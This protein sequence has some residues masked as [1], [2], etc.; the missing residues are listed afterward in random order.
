MTA[1]ERCVERPQAGRGTV[2]SVAALPLILV[3]GLLCMQGLVVGACVVQADNAAH[4]ASVAYAETGGAAA[5][6]AAARRALPGWSR[7]RVAVRVSRGR[8][9]VTLRPRVLIPGIA[10][11]LRS[12]APLPGRVGGG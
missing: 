10:P 6:I 9:V 4:A 12:L 8:V 2:E 3:V 11:T 5:A 1:L 7:G